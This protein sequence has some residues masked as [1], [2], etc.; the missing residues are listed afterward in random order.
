M[1]LKVKATK[2]CPYEVILDNAD[3]KTKC[4]VCIVVSWACPTADWHTLRELKHDKPCQDPQFAE[5]CDHVAL[6]YAMH[7]EIRDT[8]HGNALDAA[9]LPIQSVAC[10]IVDG[11][12]QIVI[13]IASVACGKGELVKILRKVSERLSPSKYSGYYADAIRKL[14]GKYNKA[15]FVTAA[16]DMVESL[17]KGV[18]FTCS[19]KFGGFA[20][21]EDA[22]KPKPQA[23]LD[24]IVASLSPI[25][26]PPME[27]N[28]KG[29]L[30]AIK[31]A[32]LV[33]KAHTF[34]ESDLYTLV[35]KHGLAA[36]V[37]AM[38]LMEY[39]DSNS[40][41][42]TGKEVIV[43]MPDA[44]SKLDAVLA[45]ARVAKWAEKLERQLGDKF[46]F[47]MMHVLLNDVG[48]TSAEYEHSTL[49]SAADVI[50]ALT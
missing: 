13:K 3:I 44:S 8:L 35:K 50:K 2:E 20:E 29:A 43:F 18:R 24:A 33:H 14:G 36:A 9:R 1:R 41:A 4:G 15:Y 21:P 47:A 31:G 46:K 5:G 17:N 42:N 37:C 19:G 40:C 28:E 11:E 27:K 30:V 32:K 39:M 22:A 48:V 7:R 49:N 38:Y 12:F 16:A 23:V 45:K 34:H 26:P 10:R 6:C 25:G